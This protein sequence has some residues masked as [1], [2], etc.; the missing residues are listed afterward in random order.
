MYFKVKAEN[1]GVDI[2]G[3]CDLDIWYAIIERQ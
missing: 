1:L 3:M 2:S